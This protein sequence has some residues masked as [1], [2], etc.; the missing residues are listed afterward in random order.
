MP[1][2]PIHSTV[3]YIIIGAGSAG[4]VVASRLAENPE[5]SVLLLE[6]GGSGMSP[7]LMTAGSM[8]LIRDWARYAWLYQTES[9]PSR[10]GRTDTWRRGRCLG[11]SSSINGMIWARGLP[12]DF[13]DWQQATSGL[14]GWES[15]LPFFIKA[16]DALGFKDPRRGQGG[17]I[18]VETFRSPHRLNHAL[19]ESFVGAGVPS[20]SDINA[21]DGCGVAITQTNQFRGLRWSTERGYLRR[22]PRNLEVRCG[23]QVQRIEFD[24]QRRAV[25]VTA[26][27]DGASTVYFK[28]RREVVLSAGA[29]ESPAILMRSGIGDP[30]QLQE[31]GIP[32]LQASPD[33]G[34]HLQ[35]H[36]DL[37]VEYEVNEPTYSDAQRWHRMLLSAARFILNRSGPA[38]SPGT[39]LFA[40]AHTQGAT[41]DPDLLIFTG[42]FGRIA[43]ETFKASTPI[44]SITPSVCRPHSRGYVR[45][46]AADVSTRPL[47]QPNLLGDVRDVDLIARAIGYVDR[48][49]RMGP[50][51]R[52][53]VRRRSP[54]EGI[55]VG[56]IATLH[57]YVRE[58]VST[59]HHS[60]GTCR[61]GSDPGAVVDPQLR[62]NGVAGLRVAD[63]SIFPRITS[64]NLN[65]PTIMVGERAA[66][67]ISSDAH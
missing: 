32:V 6:A 19:I 53:V 7:L 66:H 26:V 17:P 4:A 45:L 3:D 58:E 9:D 65:A 34:R 54:D 1:A 51:S 52:A 67:L 23:V 31:L 60:C 63:A 25:G 41:Q 12:R 43:T 61:M 27:L 57:Q 47:V 62:V 56:D 13:D 20:V 44:F 59:C 24:D 2:P 5:V 49:A 46:A 14:W 37:Y 39:Q 16:E 36:P 35:D 10:G 64:G 8:T 48:I 38:T 28:A 50:F 55:P 40:Y 21:I 15:V 11:G 33:V 42:P 29:L 22:R 18:H 30:Q